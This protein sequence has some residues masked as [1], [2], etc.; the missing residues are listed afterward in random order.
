MPWLAP[1]VYPPAYTSFSAPPAAR[2]PASPAVPNR[3]QESLIKAH[4]TTKVSENTW[5][6]ILDSNRILQ[7]SYC[8]LQLLQFVPTGDCR[9]F[10]S[11]PAASVTGFFTYNFS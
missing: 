5:D 6:S 1:R 7:Y 9:L 2:Q 4:Y 10:P 8:F 3:H 11:G